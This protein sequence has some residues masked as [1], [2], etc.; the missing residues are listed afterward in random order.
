MMMM[1]MM[2]RL[3]LGRAKSTLLPTLLMPHLLSL[4]VVHPLAA[5]VQA[6]VNVL[7]S[8]LVVHVAGL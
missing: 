7:Q 8:V 5:L 1:M 2:M 6:L 4:E 3:A